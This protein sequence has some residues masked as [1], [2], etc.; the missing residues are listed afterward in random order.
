MNCYPIRLPPHVDLRT[1]IEQ[2]VHQH[3]V[4]AGWIVTGM[5]SLSQCALRFAGQ[6][7][8]TVMVGMWEICSVAGTLSTSGIHI[9]MVVADE[10]GCCVGGHLMKGNLVRTTAELV[11]GLST[12]YSF[13][14]EMDSET[15]YPE[16]KIVNKLQ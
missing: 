7:N 9:H 3:Q 2:W 15:G 11:F 6:T 12:E 16:L 5:G 8:A 13:S 10:K 14:R 1:S 4:S